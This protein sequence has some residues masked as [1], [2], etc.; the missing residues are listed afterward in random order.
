MLGKYKREKIMSLYLDGIGSGDYAPRDAAGRTEE[1]KG[2]RQCDSLPLETLN[3]PCLAASSTPSQPAASVSLDKLPPLVFP[4]EDLA[5]SCVTG[6]KEEAILRRPKDFTRRQLALLDEVA[7]KFQL[8]EAD[9]IYLKGMWRQRLYPDDSQKPLKIL[10]GRQAASSDENFILG[11]MLTDGEREELMG[12]IEYAKLLCDEENALFAHNVA[13]TLNSMDGG[14]GESVDRKAYKLA[15]GRGSVLGAKGTDL[16][17]DIQVTGKNGSGQPVEHS[18]FVSIAEAKILQVI[19]IAKAEDFH[20]IAFQPL[21]NY[22]SIKSYLE[23][24]DSIYL[25]DRIDETIPQDAKRTYREALE[26]SGVSL[27]EM[28]NQADLPAVEEMSGNLTLNL[29]APR[30]PGGHGQWGVLFLY[31]AYKTPPPTD[32]KSHIRVF[33]N[34]DNVNSR[35]NRHIAGYMSK[36]KIPMIKLTTVATPIDRKGGKDGVRVAMQDGKAVY[37]PSQMEL[38]DAKSV[39]QEQLFYEAGQEG[40]RIGEAGKQAFNTNIMYFNLDVLHEILHELEEIIGEEKLSRVMCPSLI[41][42]PSKKGPDG[43]NYVPIDGAIGTAMHNLN[44][45]FQTSDDPEVRH[46]L[47]KRGLTQLLYFVNVP[48]TEFFTPVKNSFDIWLQASSDYYRFDTSAM[49]LEETKAGLVPPEVELVSTGPD[50]RDDKHWVEVKNI[51]DA[52]GHASTKQLKSLAVTGKVTLRDA[53]LI[54]DVKIHNFGPSV[55]LNHERYSG[56]IP[57]DPDGKL[58]LQDISIEIDPTGS[59]KIAHL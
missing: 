26:Q 24:L 28:L 39:G 27:P 16:G 55:D 32:G 25:H 47:E 41:T 51:M 48:R 53:I 12:A 23:L 56:E 50:G 30:Q 13:V 54:G 8:K 11:S 1:K 15:Q 57:R 4:E 14:I 9:K 44:A 34:G 52:F 5:P 38:A 19:G 33:Y 36:N 2:I 21:V 7:E 40:G 17:F 6:A 10:S 29:D 18:L 46:I 59:L 35:A 42:K 31:D 37:V 20:G 22:Q 43:Q 45:F 49:S 58:M 3:L